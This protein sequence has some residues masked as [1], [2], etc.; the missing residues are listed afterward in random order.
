MIRRPLLHRIGCESTATST[1]L[2]GASPACSRSAAE[3]VNTS[4]GPTKSSSSTS[5]NTSRPMLNDDN[6]TPPVQRKSQATRDPAAPGRPREMTR[7]QA[8]AKNMGTKVFSPG[9]TQVLTTPSR[10]NTL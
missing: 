2:S 4:Q 1:A 6:R 5:G 3:A 9:A 7:R 8:R 10:L